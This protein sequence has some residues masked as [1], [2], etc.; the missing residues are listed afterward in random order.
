MPLPLL[1]LLAVPAVQWALGAAAAAG[2]GG[3][4]TKKAAEAKANEQIREAER[5]TT[6]I[7]EEYTG[8]VSNMRDKVAVLAQIHTECLNH[9]ED[10]LEQQRVPKPWTLQNVDITQLLDERLRTTLASYMSNNANISAL[11]NQVLPTSDT[12]ALRSWNEMSSKLSPGHVAAMQKLAPQALQAAAPLAAVAFAGTVVL[13][14]AA[15]LQ[16]VRE[17]AAALKDLILQ[18]ETQKEQYTSALCAVSEQ[19]VSNRDLTRDICEQT[20]YIANLNFPER[21]LHL[22]AIYAAISE[23]SPF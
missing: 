19:T 6:E 3:Y 14:A 21:N 8:F 20:S 11:V 2:V 5:I 17:N 9:C 13:D 18:R 1:G 7:N 10:I 16:R 4:A 22:L 12:A 23:S 15:Q